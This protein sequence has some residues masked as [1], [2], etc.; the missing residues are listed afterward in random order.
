MSVAMNHLLLSGLSTVQYI[1]L[2]IF[3]LVIALRLL[4]II[5]IIQM[6]NE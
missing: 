3:I 2:V 4:L 6:P 1:L 5:K